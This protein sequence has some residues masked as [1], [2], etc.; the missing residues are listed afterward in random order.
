MI[1][2]VASRPRALLAAW[3]GAASLAGGLAAL[4]FLQNLE[5]HGV[6]RSLLRGVAA[7]GLAGGVW[8]LGNFFLSASEFLGVSPKRVTLSERG[9]R[10]FWSEGRE[11]VLQ[12]R[13]VTAARYLAPDLLELESSPLC[14]YAIYAQPFSASQWA[15]LKEA[16]ALHLGE[17]KRDAPENAV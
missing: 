11:V 13:D 2:L 9:V 7:A 4:A 3:K 16:V 10:L 15:A 5:E 12:W 6:L 14:R 17:A 1:D 8:L